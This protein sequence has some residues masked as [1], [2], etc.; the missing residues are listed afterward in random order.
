MRGVLGAVEEVQDVHVLEVERD[1]AARAVDLDAD[2]VL[3]AE[4]KR[5]ASKTPIAPPRKSARKVAASSTVTLPRAGAGRAGQAGVLAGQRPLVDEGAQPAGDAGDGVAGDELG[6]VD[7][8]GA[9]VAERAGA[10]L[11]L[12][13]AP[14]QRRLRVDDPVLEVLRPHV[15]QRAEPA[16]GDELPG[17]GD[18]RHA[19]VGEADHG[20]YAVGGRALGGARSSPRPPRRVLASGFSHSTCLPASRAAMAISAWVSPGVHT[21]TRSM[22]SRATRACHDVSVD[23]QPSRSA[24]AA[25]PLGVAA[26]DGGHAGDGAAGRRSAGRCARPGS[27]RRP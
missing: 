21:S 20:A 26:G 25:T 24:A 22:S 8:V 3:A 27:A 17:Q 7:D 23:S 2:R 16:L 10:G 19:P 5:V 14:R 9:D 6:E 13:Q 4:A 18:G 11:V 1:A 12:V 15:V